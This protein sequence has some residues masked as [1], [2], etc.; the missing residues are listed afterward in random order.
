VGPRQIID[1]MQ[2]QLDAKADALAVANT[3]ISD[4]EGKVRPEES[5][6]ER[7]VQRE[8]EMRSMAAG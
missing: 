5:E 1:D 6:R 7:C 3:R 8:G 4:A 2:A